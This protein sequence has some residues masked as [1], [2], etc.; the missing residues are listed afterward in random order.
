MGAL[1]PAAAAR[2]GA[3]FL[4]ALLAAAPA[5]A[6]A[7]AIVGTAHAQLLPLQRKATDELLRRFKEGG[8]A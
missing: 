1:S 3:S 8:R 5:D 2:E 4:L 6:A 7:A